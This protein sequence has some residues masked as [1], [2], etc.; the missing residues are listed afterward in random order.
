MEYSVSK[1]GD[2]KVRQ[3]MEIIVRLLRKEIPDCISIVLTGGFSRGEGPVKKINGKVIPYNDYDIQV[4]S[5]KKHSKEEVDNIAT[6]ISKRLGY[7]GIR[8]VFYPFCKENQKMGDNFYLDLKCDR[9]NDLKQMLPRIRNYELRNKSKILWGKNVC[10]VIP[11][12]RLEE[13]PLSDSAKLLLDRMSQLAEYY[14]TKGKHDPEVLTYFIQ[15]AYAA[16]C[17]SLLYLSG[18]YEIGYKTSADILYQTYQ[19]DFPDLAKKIPNLHEKIKEFI[20]WKIN[21][22]KLPNKNVEEEWFIA[23]ENI[24]EVSKYFFSKFLKKEIR[25]DEELADSIF[26]MSNKFYPPY[27]RLILRAKTGLD[28]WK[29]S[30]LF[31]PG[32]S[33]ILTNKYKKRL[34]ERGIH[35]KLRIS[36]SPDLY[37]F[38]S[39]IYLLSSIQRKRIDRRKLSCAKDRLSKVYPVKGKNWE[40]LSLDYANAYIAFF[41]QK[42]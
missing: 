20:S 3:D 37:I 27:I 28:F 15:Q 21:P 42:L 34:F 35:K 32:V 33:F 11:D 12:F 17:T 6:K 2:D 8:D 40:E 26:E 30:A 22:I 41:M 9:I 36:K 29:G 19:S 4:I 31:L 14:S 5:K 7:G 25:T 39:V 13:V 16:C 24:L 18:K 38:S 1:Q 23:K 10:K